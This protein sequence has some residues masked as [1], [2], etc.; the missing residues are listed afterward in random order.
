ME[1]SFSP[2]QMKHMRSLMKARMS[3]AISDP[4]GGGAMVGNYSRELYGEKYEIGFV[5]CLGRTWEIDRRWGDRSLLYYRGILRHRRGGLLV[6]L[7][8]ST[9]VSIARRQ[10][11]WSSRHT[12]GNQWY[13]I[14]SLWHQLYDFITSQHPI[15]IPAF[16]RSSQL[17]ST[18]FYSLPPTPTTPKSSKSCSKILRHNISVTTC[19][20]PPCPSPCPN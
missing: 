14:L 1:T 13:T 5:M 17:G 16:Q 10:K 2:S 9:R 4:R 12:L 19:P 20:S 7:G 6:L 8:N 15:M 11:Q 3:W 18:S